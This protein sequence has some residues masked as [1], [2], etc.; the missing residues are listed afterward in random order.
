[1]HLNT[2]DLNLLKVFDAMMRERNVTRAAQRLGLSQP[3]VSKAIGR[4]RVHL[5]DD[6]FIRSTKGMTATAHALELAGP[7]RQVL[8][9]LGDTLDGAGFNPQTSERTFRL[10]AVDIGSSMLLP[11]LAGYVSK[12]APNVNLRLYPERGDALTKLDTQEADFALLPALKLPERFGMMDLDPV[13][14]VLL[15]RQGH[16]LA[17]GELTPE[18]YCEHSHLLVT[19]TGEARGFV[20]DFLEQNGLSRRIAMTINSFANGIA[21]VA[22]TDMVFA[23]PRGFAETHAPLSN[24]VIRQAPF[25]SPKRFHQ[26]ALVWNKKLTDHAAYDWFRDSVAGLVGI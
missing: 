1:M 26:S 20:D 12:E 19:V 17:Q 14:F 9:L 21:I 23:A 11:K 10:V 8:T 25:Q 15:M 24:L 22:A 5:K 16:P 2:M 18:R 13:E 4:L 6:L 7:I 3:A